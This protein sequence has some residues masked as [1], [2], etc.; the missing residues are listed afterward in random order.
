MGLWDRVMVEETME[1]REAVHAESV[2]VEVSIKCSF[3]LSS[4]LPSLPLPA[5]TDSAP[6]CLLRVELISSWNRIASG[7]GSEKSPIFYSQ[8]VEL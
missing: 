4:A 7:S 1:K 3:F 2:G 8:G 6:S 5:E